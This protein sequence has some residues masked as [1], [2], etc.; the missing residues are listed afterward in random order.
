MSQGV[1]TTATGL[2]GDAEDGGLIRV[3]GLRYLGL[4][5]VLT[6]LKCGRAEGAGAGAPVQLASPQL[7][8]TRSRQTS[9]QKGTG[10]MKASCSALTC[11]HSCRLHPQSG[12]SSYLR[13]PACPSYVCATVQASL[14]ICASAVR[15][16][17]GKFSRKL[18]LSPSVALSART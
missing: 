6:V 13:I 7:E 3:E 9:L 4:F 18:M 11:S 15:G 10:S 5:S 12:L 14:P 8:E 2:E 16:F 17:Q 1:Q